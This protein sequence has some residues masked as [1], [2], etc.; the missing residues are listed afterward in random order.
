VLSTSAG[1][2]ELMNSG[3]PVPKTPAAWADGTVT[4]RVIAVAEQTASVTAE[5]IERM[6]ELRNGVGV[7]GSW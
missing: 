3:V 6:Q 7:T 2:A 4:P 1:A 5:R